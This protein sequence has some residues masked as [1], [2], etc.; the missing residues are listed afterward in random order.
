VWRSELRVEGLQL[1]DISL[2]SRV[3]GLGSRV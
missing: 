2:Q 1:R 3:K